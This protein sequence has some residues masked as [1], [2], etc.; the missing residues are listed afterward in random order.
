MV[1][2][3]RMMKVSLSHRGSTSAASLQHGAIGRRGR[4]SYASRSSSGAMLRKW[5]S[6]GKEVGAMPHSRA[7]KD[8]W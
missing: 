1:H 5:I 8:Q 7:C 4:N 6:A 3:H 2:E